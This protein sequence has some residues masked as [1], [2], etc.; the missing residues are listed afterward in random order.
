[1]ALE[2]DWKFKLQELDPTRTKRLNEILDF[3]RALSTDD[4]AG[5]QA[6]LDELEA[7]IEGLG[8]LATKDTVNDADWSGADLA[9]ANGGTGASTAAAARS[10][11][12]A[13]AAASPTFT[14]TMLG[15]DAQL[16]GQMRASV[17]EADSR[18]EVNGTKVL[19]TQGAAIANVATAAAAPTQAE[20]NA[21]VTAFNASLARLRAHGLINT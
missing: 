15:T 9:I 8:A 2:P 10:S 16:T 14:G 13:L 17:L 6:A 12:G 21:L 7:T 18:V 3:L 11:L 4:I 19:G 20:F 5:L 1:M